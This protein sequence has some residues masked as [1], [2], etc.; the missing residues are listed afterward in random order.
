MS[1]VTI[2]SYRVPR[3]RRGQ[4]TAW[5]ML[6]IAGGLLGLVAVAGA[7]AWSLSGAPSGGAGGAIPV[8]EPDPRPVKIRPEARGGLI[9]PN[10][11]QIVL[12]PPAVRRAMERS[13]GAE[14]RLAP[15]PEAPMLDRLREQIA[16]PVISLIPPIEPR[17]DQAAPADPPRPATAALPAIAAPVAA[18]IAGSPAPATIPAPAPPAAPLAAPPAAPR[19]APAGG[20]V[21]V[22][23][24]ALASEGAAR[25]EWARLQRRIP[26]LGGQAPIVI[27]FDRGE[28]RPPLWRLRLSGLPDREAARALCG[29]VRGQGGACVLVGGGG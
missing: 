27:R 20:G 15:A 8:V 21:T 25:A 22:Q 28:G 13:Q 9:V 1:D 4:A 3:E 18:P 24:G 7:I 16:P 6:A 11:D 26:A 29:D 17:Q 23:L 19:A 5:R 12:E 14:S 10:T 2:P